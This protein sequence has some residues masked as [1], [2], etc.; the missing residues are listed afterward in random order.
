MNFLRSCSRY[1]M[2][3]AYSRNLSLSAHKSGEQHVIVIIPLFIFPPLLSSFKSDYR[4]KLQ[5]VKTS[6]AR[7]PYFNIAGDQTGNFETRP[8]IIFTSLVGAVNQLDG[9]RHQSQREEVPA[10]LPFRQV[11]FNHLEPPK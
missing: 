1:A 4:E 9:C 11:A 6:T 3:T 10:E 5:Q 8:K 7:W 2:R